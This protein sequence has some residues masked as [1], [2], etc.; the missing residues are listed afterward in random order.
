MKNVLKVIRTTLIGGILFVIPIFLVIFLLSKV[1]MKLKSLF[2]PLTNNWQFD[3]I[4]GMEIP[5][6]IILLVLLLICYIAGLAAKTGVAKKIINRIEESL[7]SNIPGYNFMKKTGENL[8]GFDS[9]ES[10]PVVIVKNDS[11][12]QFGFLV[13]HV[14]DTIVAVYIPGVPSPWS[15][16]LFF[17]NIELIKEIDMTYKEALGVIKNLGAGSGKY[18]DRIVTNS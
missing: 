9:A 18:I 7:L 11:V 15:G 6:L 12:R 13:E 2:E 8:V 17:M 1:F 4:F 16:D 14:N 10:Y 5:W 3:T